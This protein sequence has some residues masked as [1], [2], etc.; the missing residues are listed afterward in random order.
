MVNSYIKDNAIYCGDK[1]ID[2]LSKDLQRLLPDA[3]CFS[4]TNLYYIKK[5]YKI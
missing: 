5:F 3:H 1:I 2:L 4:R